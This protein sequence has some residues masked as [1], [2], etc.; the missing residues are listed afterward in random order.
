MPKKPLWH[1][2]FLSYALFISNIKGMFGF[3]R[4]H[5]LYLNT[6]QVHLVSVQAIFLWLS[7]GIN[8]LD[9]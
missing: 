5:M 7:E 6:L 9:E 3:C 1:L 8:D 2:Y 4:I